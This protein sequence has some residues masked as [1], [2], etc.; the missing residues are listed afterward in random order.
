MGQLADARARLAQATAEEEQS[1]VKLSSAEKDLK[2][3]QARFKDVE[4][5]ASEG[6][7][8]LAAMKT[9]VEKA[10]RKLEQSGWN[11]EKEAQGETAL[12]NARNEV[13]NLTDV[14]IP[15]YLVVVASHDGP[16]ATRY[17]QAEALVP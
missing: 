10:R 2:A 11:A 12:R 17:H 1:K 8:N 9:E 3:L 13:R 16:A 14:C 6:K 4:R 5:D 7:R 15:L